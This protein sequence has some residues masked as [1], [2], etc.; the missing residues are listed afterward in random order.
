M[1]I[2]NTNNRVKFIQRMD[3]MDHI[4]KTR[5]YLD[6]V[7]EHINN[8]QR[9]FAEIVGKCIDLADNKT[10]V[11]LK[12]D[13]V[14]HD[15]SKLSGHEFTQYRN[16]FYPVGGNA[17]KSEFDAAWEHHKANNSHHHEVV[18]T[19]ADVIHMVIDW[20]AMAYKFG[21]SAQ[22]YYKANKENINLKDWQ[23]DL[24]HKIFDRLA[25]KEID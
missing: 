10:W 1:N 11:S 2:D 14:K 15:I 13:V 19:E 24:M 20:T 7:E 4:D 18:K 16:Y 6:Y 12:Q 5:E 22:S 21:D 3:A 25:E 23:L 17:D 9:A 8:V